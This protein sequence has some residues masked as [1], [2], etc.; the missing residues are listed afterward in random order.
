MR[1]FMKPGSVSRSVLLLVVALGWPLAVWGQKGGS[2]GLSQT[3]SLPGV[4]GGFNHMSVDAARQRLFAAAPTN[5]TL[6]VVDLRSGKPLRSLEGEKPA[7]ALYAREFDQLYVTRGQGVFIYSG[8]TLEMVASVG[9]ESNLDEMQYDPQ[10]K[11]LYVGCM[12]EGKTGIA[13]IALPEGRLV[14]K[15]PLPAK[16][17]G[18]AVERSGD[19]IFANMPTLKQVAVMD[20]RRRVALEPWSLQDV[21]GN[22]PIGLDED[23]HRLFIGARRPARLVVLDTGT[24]KSVAEVDINSDTDDLFYDPVRRRVYL[25]CG[26]GFVDVVQ[27]AGG[28]RYELM[29]RVPTVAG[30]RTSTFSSSLSSFYLG[31]P[32]RGEKPA[33]IRVFTIGR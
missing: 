13:V 27:D 15:I 16:P 20:R 14:G 22:T 19:R 12:S 3:I 8:K 5:T 18:I 31:V 26:E 9:L 1:G 6:E 17:Q 28:D 21:E 30:A 29:A 2:L 11:E 24:G 7:A 33:E 25:S 4:Q 10:A 32:R 23:R